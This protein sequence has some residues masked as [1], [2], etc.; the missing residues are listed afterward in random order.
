MSVETIHPEL[1]GFLDEYTLIEDCLD[2]QRTIKEKG[3]EYLPMPGCVNTIPILPTM[4][5][6]QKEEAVLVNRHLLSKH[7][8]RYR[9]YLKRAVFYNVA[10]RTLSGLVGKIFERAP[11]VNLP[12]GLQMLIE[13]AS[14]NGT[15]LEQ[16]T[17]RAAWYVLGM[18]RCSLMV[19][20]P[21]FEKQEQTKA[22]LTRNIVRPE[23]ILFDHRTV[24]NWRTKKVN[25]R[26]IL[27][28]VN[29][30]EDYVKSDDG[31]KQEFDIQYKVL[32]LDD[33]NVYRIEI[34]RR[35]VGEGWSIFE[36]STPIA[37]NNKPFDHIPFTFIGAE[38]NSPSVD[39]QPL[40]DLCELNIAHYINS[41]DHEE[42][43]H[44]VGQ[45]TPWVSGL[46]QEWLDTQM[47]GVFEL[48][49]RAA[50]PLPENATAGVL[51]VGENS[52]VFAAMEHKEK[53]MVALGAKLV[54]SKTVQRTATEASF[55]EA[56]ETSTLHNS[57]KNVSAAFLWALKEAALFM[58]IPDND[59]EFELASEFDL[60][61]VSSE[62]IKQM[63][64]LSKADILTTSEFR[65]VLHS[66]GW[67]TLTDEEFA[68]E[69]KKQRDLIPP[70]DNYFDM[71]AEKLNEE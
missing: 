10:A 7:R 36:V 56:S 44:I 38:D 63:L 20:F 71:Q 21:R 54:E 34:W 22:D 31:F 58:N 29:I 50:V 68:K 13:D 32:R 24:I 4:T 64:E 53:Q 9:D 11:N 26:N 30:K 65:R 46:T 60:L 43:V 12:S 35:S 39:R 25:G 69:I 3:T 40:Y 19:D 59:I 48:G 2:G 23:I 28:M 49:S 14:G 67:A 41:A 15:S 37:Y 6:R 47:G 8:E 52:L 1:V 55:E 42:A 33:D 62:D 61:R 51:E 18:G 70:V 17:K 57:A 45:P 66:A 5:D 27:S 16:M